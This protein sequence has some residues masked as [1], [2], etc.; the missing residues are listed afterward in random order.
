VRSLSRWRKLIWTLSNTLLLVSFVLVLYAGGLAAQDAYAR[1]AARGDTPVPA[2]EPVAL[3]TAAQSTSGSTAA[4][5]VEQI[6]GAVPSA[7]PATHQSTVSR[8]IIPSIGVDSKVVET[9][10]ESKQQ[11]GQEVAVWLV[12]EYTVGQ[13]Q[14]SANPGE[15]GNIVLVGHVAGRSHAF[16]DLYYVR[17]G[18]R[19]T[20]Y[21]AGQPYTYVVQ[22]RLV[23]T[24]A[25][26]SAAQQAANARYIDP[27]DH[28]VLTLVTC[29]PPTGPARFTQRV[30]VRAVPIATGSTPPNMRGDS[31]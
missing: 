21:S 1:Y 26:V 6:A 31:P 30:V 16:Q 27:T 5:D 4:A 10:W 18:D 13:L 9:G 17:Y 19:I 8:V 15:K 7:V 2:P 25:G 23:L 29:W 20:I 11:H 22:Q 12:P 28:E 14:G 3:T 24:E